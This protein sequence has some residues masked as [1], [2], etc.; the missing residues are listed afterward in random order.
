MF[1]FALNNA[2][3]FFNGNE[4]V[5]LT[6]GNQLKTI[7]KLFKPQAITLTEGQYKDLKAIYGQKSAK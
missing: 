6:N 4:I 7:D 5:L 2:T 3:Y 1:K